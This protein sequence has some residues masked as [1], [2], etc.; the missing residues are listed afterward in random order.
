M[1]D[2]GRDNVAPTPYEP[3]WAEIHGRDCDAAWQALQQGAQ[4]D[5]GQRQTCALTLWDLALW[6]DQL[7][8]AYGWD[9]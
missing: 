6:V 8:R 1:A 3:S 9:A 5:D 4:V 7:T 2:Y